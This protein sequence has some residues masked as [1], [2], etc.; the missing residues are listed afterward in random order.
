[1]KAFCDLSGQIEFGNYVPTRATTIASGRAKPLRDFVEAHAICEKSGSH[2]RL[3]V[4]GM[5]EAVGYEAQS[6][7]LIEFIRRLKSIAPKGVEV[8]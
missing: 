7:A 4:P 8:L 5:A 6:R 2:D 3:L 1:M